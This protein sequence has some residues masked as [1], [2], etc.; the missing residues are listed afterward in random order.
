[1]ANLK[2]I[3]IRIAS[4][5]NTRQVTSAM[6]MVSAAKLRK[7]QDAV[8]KIKPYA[9]KM[10]YI[11]ETVSGAM[12]EQLPSQLFAARPVKRTLVV[13]LTSNKGLCGVFNSNATRAALD[14]VSRERADQAA[15]GNVIYYAIGKSGAEALAKQGKNV[16]ERD[17][18]AV[19]NPTFAATS[20]HV[21][22]LVQMYESGQCD[23]VVVFYN[24][25]KNT[26][27]QV[28]R[29]ETL[30]P[31][32]MTS[33]EASNPPDY[34]LEPGPEVILERLAPRMLQIA[35][36]TI[37]LD[38]VAAEHGARMTAMHIATDNATQLLNDLK[39]TYNKARQDSIT[40]ELIEIVTGANALQG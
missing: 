19:N 29:S 30:L 13:L 17:E 7:A 18:E 38:S 9:E 10:Q 12:S 21:K 20:K 27:T 1:M 35:F 22:K 3:R 11:V 5:A 4:V 24:S 34:I 40:N 37:A 33:G 6:K 32:R 8:T 2:E 23:E 31:I 36:H 15:K 28:V 26:G 16:V 39:L 25:F 14:W